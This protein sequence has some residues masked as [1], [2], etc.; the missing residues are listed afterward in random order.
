MPKRPCFP[1]LFLSLCV[2]VSVN[3]SL[4]HTQFVQIIKSN[5]YIL[6]EDPWFIYIFKV[7]GKSWTISHQKQI[8]KDVLRL[9]IQ[10]TWR[11]G[12]YIQEYWDWEKIEEINGYEVWAIPQNNIERGATWPCHAR[13]PEIIS[14]TGHLEVGKG[15]K[16]WVQF[17]AFYNHQ[18]TNQWF[19]QPHGTGKIEKCQV[20]PGS[21]DFTRLVFSMW[22]KPWNTIWIISRWSMTLYLS[23][24]KVI[25]RETKGK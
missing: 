4:T 13:R 2:S 15:Q 20:R 19:R 14:G 12:N 22:K 16:K 23:I 9:P 7:K 17:Q 10:L 3:F 8:L 1:P 6:S 18:Q 21:L 5:W 25:L 11:R 24:S